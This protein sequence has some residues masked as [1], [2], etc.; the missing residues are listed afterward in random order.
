MGLITD[1]GGVVFCSGKFGMIEWCEIFLRDG[2]GFAVGFFRLWNVFFFFVWF[3]ILVSLSG[4]FISGFVFVSLLE[5]AFRGFKNVLRQ[6]V[7]VEKG[8]RLLSVTVHG[9]TINY[10]IVLLSRF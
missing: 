8:L 10:R 9:N 1:Y 2:G 4:K 5:G 3:L 7:A 6:F